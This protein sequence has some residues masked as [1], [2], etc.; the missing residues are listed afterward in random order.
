MRLDPIA[1]DTFAYLTGRAYVWLGRPQKAIPFLQ[2]QE[3]ATPTAPFAHIELAVAYIEAGRES[4]ARAEA[5]EFMR[6][7]PEFVLF[8]AEKGPFKNIAWNQRLIE[9]LRKAGLK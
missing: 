7:S 9:D 3:A 8:P 2:R 6:A 4:D 5:G 1:R